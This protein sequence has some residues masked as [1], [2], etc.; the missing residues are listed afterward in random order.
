MHGQAA[1]GAFLRDREAKRGA[2]LRL[3]PNRR[4]Q[5]VRVRLLPPIPVTDAA[6]R[7]KFRTVASFRNGGPPYPPLAAHSSRPQ[8]IAPHRYRRPVR[9]GRPGCCPVLEGATSAALHPPARIHQCRASRGSRRRAPHRGSRARSAC[10]RSGPFADAAPAV[11][12]TAPRRGRTR[13]VPVSRRR[14]NT[15]RSRTVTRLPKDPRARVKL[16]ERPQLHGRTSRHHLMRQNL[17][18]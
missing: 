14:M 10:G 1:I 7:T 18:P 4:E 16:E 5:P 17:N 2:P 8:A 6:A 13:P 9:A 11:I 3:L 15:S 12:R